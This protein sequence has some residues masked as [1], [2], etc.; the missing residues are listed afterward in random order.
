MKVLI[1]G[2]GAREHALSWKIS[3]SIG[4]EN[5]FLHPGNFGT[6]TF[7]FKNFGDIKNDP[8]IL[9]QIC[10]EKKIELVV[11]GP[12]A[13]LAAGYSDVFRKNS[14]MVV[15]P[16]KK[17]AIFET[18]KAF[19]KDFMKRALIPTAAYSVINDINELSF[20][21]FDFPV[22]LKLDGLAQGKGVSIVY[23]DSD[24]RDFIER[25][26]KNF[27]NHKIIIE[28]F[29]QG[30]ELSYL[31][32]TD[33][34]NFLPLPT[35]TDYKRALDFDKGKNTGGMGAISPSPFLKSS[36]QK[37]II[38]K[39]INPFFNQLEIEN[40][41]F[42]GV[43]Y[44]GIIIDQYEDP[45]VLEFN[46]R[47]GDPES[48]ATLPL[49]ENDFLDALIAVA[50]GRLSNFSNLKMK[51]LSSVYVVLAAENY[52]DSPIK[53]DIITGISDLSPDVYAFFSAIASKNGAFSTAGGRVMGIGAVAENI[54]K[55][56]KL[57]YENIKKIYFRGMHYRTDIGL[58]GGKNE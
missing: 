10:K 47:F 4:I 2:A 40:F 51:N 3:E 20:K 7:G 35:A 23:S 16:N 41:D 43:I 58:I 36:T 19:A 9:A 53:G 14:L 52:P 22:V 37:K 34:K 12:E 44:F 57:V 28:K 27:K 21:K 56:R 38:D 49:L 5:V 25:T 29:I 13:Y 8:E 42:L 45:Y 39:I 6:I 11:I 1:L 26:K 50:Q 55:A 33:G 30:K 32:L 54:E 17:S 31:C 24:V 15:G 48:E 18:S 46:V